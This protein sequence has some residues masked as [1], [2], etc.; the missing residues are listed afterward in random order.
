MEKTLRY[1]IA[2]TLLNFNLVV[3]MWDVMPVGKL[4]FVL[5]PTFIGVFYSAE[6]FHI[7]Q[8]HTAAP[9]QI[10]KF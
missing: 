5:K 3:L 4:D 8:I 7:K 10:I 2:N 1:H 6:L 9:E